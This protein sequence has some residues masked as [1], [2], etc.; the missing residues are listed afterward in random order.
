MSYEYELLGD[1]NTCYV[2]VTSTQVTIAPI[3]G[4]DITK[5]TGGSYFN[6]VE[7]ED[8]DFVKHPSG[9]WTLQIG[10][11]YPTGVVRELTIEGHFIDDTV[12][13]YTIKVGG[14][15]GVWGY[16]I[17]SAIIEPNTTIKTTR[18]NTRIYFDGEI[19]YTTAAADINTV[20]DLTQYGGPQ[21]DPTYEVIFNGQGFT[22]EID[23][24]VYAPNVTHTL[25]LNHGPATMTGHGYSIDRVDGYYFDPEEYA[26][27]GQFV[28]VTDYEWKVGSYALPLAPSYDVFTT[29]VSDDVDS[30]FNTIYSMDR[31]KVVELSQAL[32]AIYGMGSGDGL[33]LSPYNDSMFVIN[34]LSLPF[35][36]PNQFLSDSE[37]SINV[38]STNTGVMSKQLVNDKLTID[39]GKIQVDDLHGSSMDYD[40]VKYQ[41]TLPYLSFSLD[42]DPSYVVG[43]EVS[44]GLVVDAYRGDF[45]VNVYSNGDLVDF[46]SERLGRVIPIHLFYQTVGSLANPT[47]MENGVNAAYIRAIRSEVTYARV[48]VEER[49]GDCEGFLRVQDDAV[50]NLPGVSNTDKVLTLLREGVIVRP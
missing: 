43:K 8:M 1:V 47:Y 14:E 23:G 10:A 39:L 26:E 24:D 40:Q 34:L 25:P 21:P 17:S 48:G 41:L 2:R 28:R 4:N 12:D 44:A 16:S 30:P 37:A 18:D 5:I 29:L 50:V 32:P 11:G 20:V 38:G 27:K 13:H 7:Y 9:S 19:V 42:L 15:G 46:R 35:K 33:Q 36:I 3:H 49:I 22:V 6:F 31:D 45:T